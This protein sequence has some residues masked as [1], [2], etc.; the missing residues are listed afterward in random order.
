MYES[1]WKCALKKNTIRLPPFLK[2][3]WKGTELAEVFLKIIHG[4]CLLHTAFRESSLARYV[5]NYSES[6]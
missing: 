4:G 2:Y 6:E 3:F 5:A 1:E